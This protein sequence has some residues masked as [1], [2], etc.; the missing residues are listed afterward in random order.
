MKNFLFLLLVLFSLKSYSQSTYYWKGGASGSWT[1][2]SNWS[3]ASLGG[4]SASTTPGNSNTDIVVIDLSNTG[5][6]NAAGTNV[7]ITINSMPTTTIASLQIIRSGGVTGSA[8]S[9]VTLGTGTNRLTL[10]GDA[11]FGTAPVSNVFVNYTFDMGGNSIT[12][13]GNLSLQS[14]FTH[15]N[16]GN[17]KFTGS[18]K[19]IS[20]SNPSTSNSTSTLNNLEIAVGSSNA[21]N[22][23]LG[24]S[25]QTKASSLNLTGTVTF[26]SGKLTQITGNGL[27]SNVLA[28][29]GGVSGM[30]TTACLSSGA[31]AA[32][33]C[34][35]LNFAPTSSTTYDFYMDATNNKVNRLNVNSSSTVNLKSSINPGQTGTTTVTIDG[36]L[37]ASSGVSVTTSSSSIIAGAGTFSGAGTL[38]WSTTTAQTF[39]LANVSNLNINGGTA[40][41]ASILASKTVNITGTLTLSGNCGLTIPASSTLAMGSGST[42]SITNAT[43]ALTKSGTYSFGTGVNISIGATRNSGSELTGTVGTYNLA[44]ASGTYTLASDI[45]VSGNITISSG[46][47]IAAGTRNISLKG[48]WVNNAGITGYTYS[49]TSSTVTLNGNN[50]GISGATNFYNLTKSV[51]TPLTITFP[52]DVTETINGTLTLNGI[53]GNILTIISSTAG[54][55]AI[56]APANY[57]IDYVSV[58]D[59]N[60]TVGTLTPTN[61]LNYGNLSGWG[62]TGTD[63]IW[64]GAVDN[65]WT[66]TLNFTPNGTPTASDN[67]TITKSSS[68][69]LV[70]NGTAVTASF[71]ISSGNAVSLG[72]N[73]LSVSGN[74]TNNGTFSG[75]TGTVTITGTT[76][77]TIS[78]G[79]TSFYGL[80]INNSGGVTLNTPI[81]VT[82]QLSLNSGV[83]TNS[84]NNVTLSNGA[85]ISRGLTSS[86]LSSAPIFGVATSDRVN[87]TISATTTAG[88]ELL[89]TMGKVGTLTV[90]G[91]ITYTLNNDISID[92]LATNNASGVL[93]ASTY[94]ITENPAGT[95]TVSGTGTI[96]T[97]NTSS[98]PFPSGV[99]WSGLVNYNGSGSQTIVTGSYTNLTISG[100]RISTPTITLASGTINLSGNISFTA[101]GAVTHAVSGNTLNV[102]GS[103]AQTLT[104]SA[105]TTPTFNILIIANTGGANFTINNGINV[106][107]FTINANSSATNF[108]SGISFPVGIG[109]TATIH[110]TFS[111]Q[112]GN[113]AGS[114]PNATSI[115][116]DN[117]SS[118]IIYA[119]TS[120]A[121]T[122]TNYSYYNLTI[123]GNRTSSPVT[124]SSGTTYTIAGN[125]SFTAT[126]ASY[127]T[128]GSIVDFNGTGSQTI[129]AFSYNSIKISGVRSSATITLASG[130][131]NL[132]GDLT[133]TNTGTT[134]YTTTGNTIS[135]NGTTA[136]SLSN[137]GSSSPTFNILTINNSG[138]VFTTI[139]TAISI[140]STFNVNASSSCANNS[141]TINFP[142]GGIVNLNGTFATLNSSLTTAFTGST[143]PTI[144]VSNTTS[145]INYARNASQSIANL[146]YFNLIISGNRG[147]ATVTFAGTT[148]VAGNLSINATNAVY[149]NTGHT[150]NFNG[151][152]AQV[153]SGT[154][155]L[156]SFNNFTINKS[157]G[158]LTL[159]SSIKIKG[160]LTPTA[161]TLDLSNYNITLVS[162]SISNTAVVGVVGGTISY[163]GTGRFIVE[164]FIP[165]GNRNYR[166]LTPSVSNAG[167]VWANWQESATTAN[168]NPV[169][170]Y[171]IFITGSNAQL[172]A[173]NNA[174][175]GAD[176]TS[177]G[178]PSLFTYSN[179]FSSISNTKSLSLSP[180]AGYRVLIRGDRS[181]DLF[182]TPQT[183]AMVSDA[184]IRSTG[185]LVTGSV[186]YGNSTNVGVNLN[187]SAGVSGTSSGFSLIGNPYACQ[188]NWNTLSRTNLVGTY[189][190]GDPT[191]GF[192]VTY[193]GVTSSS[194]TSS[195]NQYIQPG[196]AFFV[197]N[198]TSGGA[199]QIVINE[200]NKE[201]ASSKTAVFGIANAPT[202]KLGVE[203]LK[204]ANTNYVITDAAVVAFSDDFTNNLDQ[205][206]ADKMMN[207][208]DNVGILNANTTLSIECRKTP[209]GNDVIPI[210]LSKLTKGTTYQLQLNAMQFSIAGYRPYLNDTYKQT[211]LAL[212]PNAITKVDFT[213]DTAIK[214]SFV[215]RFSIVFKPSILPISNIKLIAKQNGGETKLEFQTSNQINIANYLI[216]RSSNGVDFQIIGSVMAKNTNNAI[217]NFTDNAI[218]TTSVYYRVKAVGINNSDSRYSEVVLIDPVTS[219]SRIDIWP[220]PI[221]G[222]TIKLKLSNIKE[223]KYSLTLFDKAGKKTELSEKLRANQSNVSTQIELPIL[224]V[225]SYTLKLLNIENKNVEYKTE[226]IKALK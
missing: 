55:K 204:K 42:L 102:N 97:Q 9:S 77:S 124:F 117:T 23:A 94:A 36:T 148:N 181:F 11:T 86:S 71:T 211:T 142:S 104:S 199:S 45:N 215:N 58:Q 222:N 33:A 146:N 109:G 98:S 225:G 43:A 129:P 88:N 177:T 4:A 37:N 132:T 10:T 92:V 28:F 162:T 147:S 114:F 103:T 20:L 139:L 44:V 207:S 140:G 194:L 191:L 119:R 91:A 130:T 192:Y 24:A 178:N 54:T 25:S 70:I 81:T 173:G 35:Q 164:R 53:V 32:T 12:I 197:R 166:D 209:S 161:G 17:L 106:S 105:T 189:W 115:V 184:T 29:I 2:N 156:P 183:N 48:N 152:G 134:S 203:L 218:N 201:L 121:Q 193:N 3:T 210:L 96:N 138:G 108:T 150:F 21:L 52:A 133:Y 68:N 136:Q 8:T 168:M 49:G 101:S 47:V 78:G 60:N 149:S 175:T 85:T 187:S 95:L 69:D 170:G 110:G 64:T 111:T 202:N 163:G 213:I 14:S 217:Y 179:G 128:T 151:S 131:I 185:N 171:G 122:I 18:G 6:A 82:N 62:F 31:L 157:G 167:S 220:N 67:V 112:S 212:N 188:I 113:L 99:L 5:S 65:T 34:T 180:Y 56:I 143:A 107:T 89:G 118:T 41:A 120:S 159:G 61:S 27:N 198:T 123:A 176:Y 224:T 158:T 174:S 200:S 19:A 74:L 1:T 90:S 226:L 51:A 93:D 79:A 216:E 83:L 205:Y 116:V 26:T 169:P 144:N 190:I 39:A 219:K 154:G 208:A 80:T 165:Q 223:G 172:S 182:N 66:N 63:F 38:F 155:T 206:D 72:A 75:G 84:T 30:S 40:G 214:A 126:N 76:A 15:Q 135:F 50:Q 22:Y 141:N 160:V 7:A 127:T 137:T 13:G 73:S 57:S 195:V 46:A 145:T 87:V 196:Q 125:L 16:C 153:I 186:T 221:V 59:N 100:T